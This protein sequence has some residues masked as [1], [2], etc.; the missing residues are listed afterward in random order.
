[1]WPKPVRLT[2]LLS[3]KV[4][5]KICNEPVNWPDFLSFF[6]FI[7]LFQITWLDNHVHVISDMG[8][9]AP[10]HFP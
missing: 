3:Q 1:M 8:G 6:M 5:V 7:Y 9:I 10:C 2:G 4:V